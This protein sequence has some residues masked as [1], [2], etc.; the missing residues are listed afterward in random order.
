MY[1]ITFDDL[2]EMAEESKDELW[3]M[4]ES[5]GRDA[6]IYLHWS[7]GHYG[8]FFDDYHINIDE[9]GSLYTDT[10]DLAEVKAHTEG[11]N[12]GAVG[13]AL[14]CCYKASPTNLGPEPPTEKQVE[15][16]AQV[17]AILCQGLDIPLDAEHVMTHG[18]AADEDE[19]GLDDDEPDCRWDL[20]KLFDADELGTGGDIIR[21]K[22]HKYM[23]A[24][25]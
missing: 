13:V 17:V 3:D 2:K 21:E 20:A 19:Y 4:A 15:S 10:D 22:A 6:M 24:E 8:S 11:R 12:G 25:V 16:M 23:N 7:A 14:A 5:R 18:E 1:R 9:D